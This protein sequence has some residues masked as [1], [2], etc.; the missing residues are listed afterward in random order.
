MI[1]ARGDTRGACPRSRFSNG[2]HDYAPIED[3]ALVKDNYLGGY[4]AAHWACVD[5]GHAIKFDGRYAVAPR[6]S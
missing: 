1:E 5:C 3:G 4:A 6:R 2:K